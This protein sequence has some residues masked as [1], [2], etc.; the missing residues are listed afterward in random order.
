MNKI[1]TNITKLDDYFV[2]VNS[3]LTDFLAILV[4]LDYATQSKNQNSLLQT[5]YIGAITNIY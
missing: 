1:S 4:N 5:T 2:P 3:Q